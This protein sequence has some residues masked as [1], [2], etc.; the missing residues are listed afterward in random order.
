[1]GNR[2]SPIELLQPLHN[3]FSEPLIMI[4]IILNNLEHELIRI[5]PRRCG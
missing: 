4:N 2:F 1:M 5:A 3:L